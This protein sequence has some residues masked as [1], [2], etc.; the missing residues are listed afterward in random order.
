MLCGERHRKL[1]FHKISERHSCGSAKEVK[2][3]KDTENVAGP[4]R[5][6]DHG[7]LQ[8]GGDLDD[9]LGTDPRLDMG[10]T[11]VAEM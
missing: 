7:R 10:E 9:W 1:W 8:G 5:R 6:T 3:W 4:S 11:S 2:L